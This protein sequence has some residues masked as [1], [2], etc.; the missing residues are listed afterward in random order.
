MKVLSGAMLEDAREPLCSQQPA[1]ASPVPGLAGVLTALERKGS[2]MRPAQPSGAVST[3]GV[4]HAM[5]IALIWRRE[6]ERYS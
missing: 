4:L 5:R 3:P 2:G 1:L 6:C